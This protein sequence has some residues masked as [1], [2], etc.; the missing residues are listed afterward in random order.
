MIWATARFSFDSEWEDLVNCT[1]YDLE[2]DGIQLLQ[3]YAQGFKTESPGYFL[4]VNDQSDPL[5]LSSQ[6]KE[7]IVTI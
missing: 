3:K 1:S 4:F 7:D 5:D 6:I 2:E